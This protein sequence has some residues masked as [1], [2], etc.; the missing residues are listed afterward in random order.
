MVLLR[1]S[2]FFNDLMLSAEKNSIL[3]EFNNSGA[4]NGDIGKQ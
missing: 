4:K 2:Q 1:S 3:A